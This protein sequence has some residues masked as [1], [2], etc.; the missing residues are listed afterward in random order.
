M[1]INKITPDMPVKYRNGISFGKI[2]W[3]NKEKTMNDLTELSLISSSN[4]TS[5]KL[6]N[7]FDAL[8]YFQDRYEVF[9][10]GTDFDGDILTLSITPESKQEQ[11]PFV[12]KHNIWKDKT[13]RLSIQKLFNETYRPEGSKREI[14]SKYIENEMNK[15]STDC[16]DNK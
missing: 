16:A 8:E 10:V 13:F 4:K 2:K 6:R 15:I 5:L 11:K 3:Q 14:T 9:G 7:V 12:Y 1:L